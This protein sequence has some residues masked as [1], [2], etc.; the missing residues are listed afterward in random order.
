M[1]KGRV[2]R[3]DFIK[4]SSTFLAGSAMA[5]NGLPIS[6]A[7]SG[8]LFAQEGEHVV[9]TFCEICFWKCGVDAH[10]KD[11]RVVKLTGQ[12]DHPLSNGKLCP[13]GAG[14]LGMLYDPDRLKHPLIRETVNGKQM[15]RKASWEEAI[16]VVAD[17]VLQLGQE[18]GPGALVSFTHGF[19]ASFFSRLCNSCGIIAAPSYAQ[20]R[21]AREDAFKVTYGHAVGSPESIDLPNT[22]FLVLFGSHLG[23]N[24]HNTSVQ[25]FTGGI[26]KGMRLVVVDPRYSTA[27]GKAEKW[28]PV[29]AGTD[30]ALMRAWI[31]VLVEE[32]LYDKTFVE[33]NTVGL[34]EVREEMKSVSLAET[35]AITGIPVEDI[36]KVARD[37]GRYKNSAMVYPGR[38]VNWYGDDMQ[39]SRAI[40]ILN[41]LLGNYKMPG[42]FLKYSN[43][44]VPKIKFPVMKHPRV[45]YRSKFPLAS[46][47]SAN[48]IIEHT[49]SGEPWP[50][51]GW[52]VYGCN[53]T[54][55]AADQQHT[56]DA[57]QKLKFMFAVDILPAEITSFAD[58][59][60]PECTYL[61]RYDDLHNPAYR[62]PYVAIRQPAIPPLYD[63]KPAHLIVKM[64]ADKMGRPDLFEMDI[65]T[66]LDTRLKKIGSSLQEIKVKGVIKK[67]LADLYRK[68]GEKLRFKTPSGKIELASSKMKK[69]GFDAVP[70]YTPP[71]ES[72]PGYFRLLFGRSP[73]HTFARTTN[74]RVLLELQEENDLWVNEQT[75]KD[76]GVKTGQ[77]VY[78][79]NQDGIRSSNKIRIRLTQRVRP[80]I[81]Y[82][83][84]GFGHTNPALTAGYKK[85]VLDTEMLSHTDI[86]P[87]MGSVGVQ[88]NFIKIIKEA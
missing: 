23:E 2:N 7:G 3:R 59:I 81:F 66:Y 44:N 41:A 51:H 15:F 6:A 9:K 10:V 25:D 78:I 85:G 76:L 28:L 86:D 40:A 16:S 30:L 52:L 57:M 26:A 75:G 1:S 34:D 64:L 56:Y 62:E 77:Y 42:G 60:L 27:A 35:Y 18:Y 70:K 43:Y 38:R 47:V 83:H 82:M 46:K 58:V 14:G 45:Q 12:K 53:L 20:C 32:N 17:N 88:N 63:S 33:D 65:E 68:P 11:G 31:K 55:T 8:D 39:R 67:P 4:V 73:F 29:R 49:L 84:H 80:E 5:A 37:L 69:A 50:I 71:A 87:T 24:M 21:G 48:E 74:N 54:S 19:G 36:V 61:E 79:E 13:R 22:K 72:P